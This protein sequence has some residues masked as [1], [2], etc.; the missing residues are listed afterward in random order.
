VGNL[1]HPITLAEVNEANRRKHAIQAITGDKTPE[2]V[3]PADGPQSDA[4]KPPD[5]L[6]DMLGGIAVAGAAAGGAWLLLKS[7]LNK[8][9]RRK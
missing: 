7:F 6:G 3:A 2:D 5:V 8:R 1:L 4:D 9:G